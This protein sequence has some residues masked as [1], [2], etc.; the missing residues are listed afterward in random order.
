MLRL[1]ADGR[2]HPFLF[3]RIWGFRLHG[4]LGFLNFA[5]EKRHVGDPGQAEG[6]PRFLKS[7][8]LKNRNGCTTA[9]PLVATRSTSGRIEA[10]GLQLG[11]RR[12]P[13]V[14][15][16]SQ[17]TRSSEASTSSSGGGRSMPIGSGWI[18]QRTRSW[19]RRSGNGRAS[20]SLPP[21]IPVDPPRRASRRR[22]TRTPRTPTPHHLARN[23]RE[24]R[25]GSSRCATSTGCGLTLWKRLLW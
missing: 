2:L 1:S 12:T 10:G 23:D 15:Q 25:S 6:A 13:P 8:F 16:G 21:L 4:G 24:G 3:L 18:A 17:Q 9:M 20:E 5:L 22:R 11:R 19:C 7:R 14:A